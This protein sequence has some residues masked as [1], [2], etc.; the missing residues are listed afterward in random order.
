MS[1]ALA[2]T[3]EI[4]ACSVRARRC[5]AYKARSSSTSAVAL[6][7]RIHRGRYAPSGT[8]G[9]WMQ[10]GPIA[11]GC[12]HLRW[13][14]LARYPAS[15]LH[16]D[17]VVLDG[18]LLGAWPHRLAVSHVGGKASVAGSGLVRRG[19]GSMAGSLHLL[20][21]HGGRSRMVG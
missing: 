13:L 7:I 12:Q 19:A 20:L 9:R 18:R 8:A 1:S 15:R 3:F 5:T 10:K 4:Y 14:P 16:G 21:V 2:P 6:M 11:L 17:E